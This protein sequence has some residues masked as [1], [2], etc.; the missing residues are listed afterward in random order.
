MR[1]AGGETVRLVLTD[2]RQFARL[3][4]LLGKRGQCAFLTADQLRELAAECGR[5]AEKLEDEDY[6]GNYVAW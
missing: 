4:V 3:T 1:S 5:L 6:R 2:D